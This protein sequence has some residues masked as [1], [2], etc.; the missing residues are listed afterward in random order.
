MFIW[1]LAFIVNI[2]LFPQL[3]SN[4]QKFKRIINFVR[5]EDGKITDLDDISIK[6]I[7]EG[8]KGEKAADSKEN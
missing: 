6:E 8:F 1:N 7:H 5:N 4:L 3:F 2:L